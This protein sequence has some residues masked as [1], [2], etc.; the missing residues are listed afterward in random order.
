VPN[1]T[2][3]KIV[4]FQRAECKKPAFFPCATEKPVAHLQQYCNIEI[5]I[6]SIV[7]IGSPFMTGYHLA[8]EV[9]FSYFGKAFDA[10]TAFIA[11]YLDSVFDRFKLTME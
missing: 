4:L 2:N 1:G 6:L 3:V 9:N 7:P 11:G 10:D 5:F 8:L